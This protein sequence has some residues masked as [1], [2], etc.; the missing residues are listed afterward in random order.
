MRKKRLLQ[1]KLTKEIRAAILRLVQTWAWL[2]MQGHKTGVPT[3]V[4]G[5]D[6]PPG[7]TSPSLDWLNRYDPDYETRFALCE[8]TMDQLD[9]CGGMDWVAVL[10]ALKAA[11]VWAYQQALDDPDWLREQLDE[12]D[13]VKKKLGEAFKIAS[14]KVDPNFFLKGPWQDAVRDFLANDPWANFTPDRPLRRSG[15]RPPKPWCEPTLR[16][17]RA[18]GVPQEQAEDLL[19]A[20][21]LMNRRRK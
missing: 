4:V 15:G 1:P 7:S 5:R 10:R 20:L 11:W 21:R 13:L 3:P 9:A 19:V 14:R 18:A 8:T 17:L 6:I 12:R 16:A 2:S